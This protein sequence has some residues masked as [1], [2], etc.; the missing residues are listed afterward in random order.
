M[1]IDV[2]VKK[3]AVCQM[4]TSYGGKPPVHQ[5]RVAVQFVMPDLE[6]R[7]SIHDPGVLHGLRFTLCGIRSESRGPRPSKTS[8][9]K[10]KCTR[11]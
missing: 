11:A 1:V 7:S 2:P 8:K 6:K 9:K 10:S 3:L 4:E 5:M